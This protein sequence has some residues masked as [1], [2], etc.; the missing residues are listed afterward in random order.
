MKAFKKIAVAVMAVALL[1]T[2][3]PSGIGRV[4]AATEYFAGG[5]GTALDPYLIET[6]T[7]LNNVR[8]FPSAHYKQIA[9][10][11]FSAEDYA[12][13]GS[14][15][16]YGKY[17]SPIGSASAPFSG[18]YNGNGY[19]IYNLKIYLYGNASSLSSDSSGNDGWTGDYIVGGSSIP[20]IN[21]TIGL[22]GYNTGAIKN[23]AVEGTSIYGKAVNQG[24]LYVGTIA[25]YNAGTISACYVYASATASSS[26][27]NFVGA[28]VGYNEGNITDC[29]SLGN[30]SGHY[31]GGI[32][33]GINGG[34]VSTSYSLATLTGTKGAGGIAG[35][36]VD[37]DIE[38]CYYLDNTDVGVASGNNA[39][40]KC[41]EQQLKNGA[42][43][44]GFNFDTVWTVDGRGD[45]DCPQLKS[46]K[47][48]FP[49]IKSVT[50]E[51]LPY[52]TEYLKNE[53]LLDLTGASIKINYE[54]GDYKLLEIN[55]SMVSEFDNSV[56]GEHRLKVWF[57]K[58][59]V[60]FSVNV[61]L[62]FTPGDIN[63]SGEIDIK[64]IVDLS[65]L[66]AGWQ[67]VEYNKW[68]IDPNGDKKMDLSDVVHLARFKAGWTD[69]VLSQERYSAD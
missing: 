42:T 67:G 20:T 38:N 32:A 60:S 64:D 41:T 35:Q 51:S 48:K 4:S 21:P 3:L 14:F 56:L 49:K 30:A 1:V 17:W 46:N 62:G 27:D 12:S 33:G 54:N 5:E 50:M 61:V 69:I 10:I 9:D 28:L 2:A 19:A 68:A 37:A 34:T 53:E 24:S 18:S 44:I 47:M 22:F 31:T 23:L 66:A 65:K 59:I 40:T 15:Y 7:H 45:Y 55:G 63:D 25:G 58:Y 29:F 57:E 43:Y 8:R 13:G 39:G 36:A 11:E 6:K 16:N 52:K 26:A